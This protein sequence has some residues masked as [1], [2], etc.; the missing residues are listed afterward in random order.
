[1][2]KAANRHEK[3]NLLDPSCTRSRPTL[4]IRHYIFLYMR[5]TDSA[6]HALMGPGKTGPTERLV[7]SLNTA[8]LRNR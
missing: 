5:R 2:A 8:C 6:D 3:A 7:F 4:V 1:M